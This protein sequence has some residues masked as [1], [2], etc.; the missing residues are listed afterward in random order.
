MQRLSLSIV[1]ALSLAVALSPAIRRARA[2]SLSGPTEH[3]LDPAAQAIDHTAPT[4]PP[5]TVFRISRGQDTGGSCGDGSCD[6]LASITIGVAATDDATPEDKI[7]YR[8]TLS[9][10]RL[11][12]GLTLPPTA[13]R[14][15][16]PSLG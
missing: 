14:A 2:C 16:P 10:G 6:G 4:L 3:L 11:P 1:F 9:A 13:I 7:G 5:P 15:R 8:L 12:E